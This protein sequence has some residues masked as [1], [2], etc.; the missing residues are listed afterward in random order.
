[1]VSV[2]GAWRD[3][4]LRR[5]QKV[6]EF[7]FDD[8][9]GGETSEEFRIIDDGDSMEGAPITITALGVEFDLQRKDR[10]VFE[11]QGTA[12]VVALSNGGQVPSIILAS[13]VIAHGP[14]YVVLGT[15]TPAAPITVEIPPWSM[16]WDA[17]AAIAGAIKAQTDA[18]AEIWLERNGE[19]NYQ[20]CVG[21]YGGGAQ[22]PDIRTRKNLLK[23]TRLRSGEPQATRAQV[24][25]GSGIPLVGKAIYSISAVSAGAHAEVVDLAGGLAPAQEADQFNEAYL[26][27]ATGATHEIIDTQVISPTVTRLLVGTTT[28]L[29]IGDLVRILRS[30]AKEELLYIDSPSLLGQYGK[31]CRLL[32]R[33]AL[34]PYTNVLGLNTDMAGWSG[35]LPDGFVSTAT[36][37]TVTADTGFFLTGG[38]SAKLTTAAPAVGL[39]LYKEQLFYSLVAEPMVF[40]TWV[41]QNNPGSYISVRMT[42]GGAHVAGSPFTVV[43]PLNQFVRVDSGVEAV[44]AG[45]HTLKIEVFNTSG[46]PGDAVWCDSVQVLNADAALP[47]RVGSGPARAVQAVNRYFATNGHPSASY[48]VSASDRARRDPGRYPFEGFVLGGSMAIR[49]TELD[50]TTIQRLMRRDRNLLVAMDTVLDIQGLPVDFVALS[51]GV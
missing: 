17:A 38:R 45:P 13:R 16:P 25:S 48:R 9:A 5:P 37:G 4:A 18:P 50:I 51:A 6:L 20:L 12:L 14:S 8:G 1:M 49:E 28:P 7:V 39:N 11:D 31:L 33:A 23:F 2:D 44:A 46:T 30:A 26:L 15:V 22:I 47:F 10:Y 40:S 42:I 35:A 19:T 36:A 34:D 41:A 32:E 3:R 24:R 29:A 43:T 21:T 27:D